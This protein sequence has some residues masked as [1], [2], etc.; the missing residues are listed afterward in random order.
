M[1]ESQIYIQNFISYKKL[2]TGN[3]V[4][5]IGKAILKVVSPNPTS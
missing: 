5:K 3:K 1:V 2:C 4:V